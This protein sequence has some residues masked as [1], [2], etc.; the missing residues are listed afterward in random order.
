MAAFYGFAH[1][2]SYDAEACGFH[3]SVVPASGLSEFIS[4]VFSGIMASREIYGSASAPCSVT[5]DALARSFS[6]ST[7]NEARRKAAATKASG[8]IRWYEPARSPHS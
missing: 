6:A 7:K 1:K 3:L 2:A 8:S 5:D 4:S